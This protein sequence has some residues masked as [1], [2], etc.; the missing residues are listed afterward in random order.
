MI[1]DV[2]SVL[3]GFIATFIIEFLIIWT[4]F[5]KDILKIAG[6]VFLMNLFSWPLANLLFDVYSNF[7]VIEISVVLIES[8]LIMLLFKK[9]YLKSLGI[10]LLVNFVSAVAGL[11]FT[12]VGF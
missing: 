2:W 8:V 7:I 3:G 1:I 11:I 12:M 5:R 4:L 10:S 6:Y 9:R